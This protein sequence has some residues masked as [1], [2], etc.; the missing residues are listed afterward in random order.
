MDKMVGKS[1]GVFLSVAIMVSGLF[2]GVASAAKDGWPNGLHITAPANGPKYFAPLALS[3]VLV[4]KTGMKVRVIPD[5]VPFQ[6]LK[7]FR[8]GEFDIYV[9]GAGAPLRFMQG[10]NEYA[11]KNNGPLPLTIMWPAVVESFAPMLRGDTQFKS[12]ADLKD[13][14]SIAAPPGAGPQANCYCFAAWAGLKNDQWKLVEYGSMDSA[15]KSVPLGQTD[16][17]WW[18]PDA[19]QTYEA[20]S[21]PKG[22]AWLDLDPVAD[23]EGAARATELCPEWTFGKAPAGSVK[24]AQGKKVALVP[25]YFYVKPEMDADLVYK[26]V[27]FIDENNAAVVKQHPSAGSQNL[28]SFKAVLG[29]SFMPIHAGTIRYLK[30]KGVWSAT[31]QER[32]DFN[33]KIFK[34]YIE[35]FD[36]AVAEAESKGIKAVPD[37]KEWLSI[38]E[39]HKAELPAIKSRTEFPMF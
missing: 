34:K 19:G 37:N 38:W 14:F 6:R 16:M 8:D 20:E 25:T 10:E 9:N 17:V 33:E 29:G 11:M 12:I 36:M 30:E 1:L 28:E 31:D 21:T 39:K 22:L 4:E 26:L 15:I 7:A 5:E 27:K 23:P 13:G 2:C 3:G 32:Q 24:S 35:N 18:I